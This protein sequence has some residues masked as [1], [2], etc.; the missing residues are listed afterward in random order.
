MICWNPPP[1]GWVK[2]N[3]VSGFS[4]ARQKAVSGSIIKNEEG[5]ILGSGFRV[6]HLVGTVALA[7]AIALLHGVQFASEMGFR[8]VIAE[9]DSRLVINN[10][11]SKEDDYSETRPLTWDLKALTRNFSE[12]RFQFVAREGSSVAHAMAEEGLP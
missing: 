11:N 6:H 10:I 4:I 3:V 2:L 9:S 7:E 5:N 8:Y 12:C 1:M